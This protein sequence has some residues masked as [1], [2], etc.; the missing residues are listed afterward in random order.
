[1]IVLLELILVLLSFDERK[2]YVEFLM[3]STG[4][5]TNSLQLHVEW[6]VTRL[7]VA[8]RLYRL[9]AITFVLSL[10]FNM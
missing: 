8:T 10:R 9:F 4:S 5:R 7:H 3:L 2:A 6:I 1:M